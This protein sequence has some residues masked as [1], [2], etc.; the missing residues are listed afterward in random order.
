MRRLIASCEEMKVRFAAEPLAEDEG[1]GKRASAFP[2]LPPALGGSVPYLHYLLG[3]YH[4][5]CLRQSWSCRLYFLEYSSSMGCRS[6]F[7]LLDRL[8]WRRVHPFQRAFFQPVCH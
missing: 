4:G 5:L 2:V 3:L 1:S 7:R 6:Y 8:R